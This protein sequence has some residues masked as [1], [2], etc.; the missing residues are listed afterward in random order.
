[1]THFVLSSLIEKDRKPEIVI[2][3]DVLSKLNDGDGAE[4]TRILSRRLARGSLVGAR[5]LQEG[6][7]E[8]DKRIR[9]QFRRGIEPLLGCTDAG[10][11]IGSVR[12]PYSRA[13]LADILIRYD[14]GAV[15]R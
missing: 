4:Q 8:Q 9:Q 14:S 1:V 7:L 3:N 5:L 15:S 11:V 13:W 6:V 10:A 12:Q 2:A